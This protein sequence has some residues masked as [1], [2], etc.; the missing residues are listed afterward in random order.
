M[1]RIV[2][3]WRTVIFI[4][5][6]VGIYTDIGHG[7]EDAVSAAYEW[8]IGV[9]SDPVFTING[10]AVN[11]P[12]EPCRSGERTQQSGS[13]ILNDLNGLNALFTPE[14]VSG[15]SEPGEAVRTSVQESYGKLPLYFIQNDGQVDARVQYYEKGSGQ[16][17][18]FTKKGI[19]LSLTRSKKTESA[20]PRSAIPSPQPQEHI[21][22]FPLGANKDP[23]IIAEDMQECKINYFVGSPEKWRTNI[24]TFGAVEYKNIYDGV[25]M[26]FY[27]NNRQMEY[28]V[29]VK[30]GVSPSRVQLCYEGIEDLRI[31][32][33]GDM[34]IILKEGSIIHKKPYIYQII[35]GEKRE[36]EGSF[37]IL[38][39]VCG[40]DESS[41]ATAEW[42]GRTQPGHQVEVIHR[43]DAKGAEP[44]PNL[45]TPKAPP[46]N[47]LQR[48]TDPRPVL[49]QCLALP[50]TLQRVADIYFP[51]VGE[52]GVEG[53]DTCATIAKVLKGINNGDQVTNLIP[54]EPSKSVH[55]ERRH[56]KFV[57]GFT[58]A[59]YEKSSSLVIDP[60]LEYSTYLGGDDTD[61]GY[62]IAVD[63]SGYAYV[64]GF[65]TSANF[66]VVGTSTAKKANEDV[67]VTKL[68]TETPLALIYSTYIGGNGADYGI[69]IAVDGSASAY[70]TGYTSSS[71]FPRAGTSTAKKTNYDAFVTKLGASG[72]SLEYSTYIGGSGS[73]YGQGIAVDSSGAAYVVG[74]TTSTNFPRVGTTTGHA[75]G[76]DDVF[77]TKLGTETPLALIYSTYIGGTGSELGRGI[78]L[79]DSGSAY[80]SGY[81][82]SA[83]FPVVGT[84]TGHAG[85]TYDAFVTK[86][87][88]ETPLA[89]IYSTY[90]GGDGD[91]LAIGIAVDGSGSAYISGHT[92][93]ANFPVVGTTT[94]HAGGI[95]DAFVTKLGTETPLALVYSTCIGGSGNDYCG[96]EID[97]DGSG[98]AYIIG[99]TTSTNFPVVG[100]TTSHAEGTEDAFVIKL[101]TGVPISI[102]YSTYI[103]GSGSDVALGI[104]VDGTD[105][106]YI[107]GY[108]G[109]SNFPI[110]GTSTA[111]KSGDDA[112][113]TKLLFTPLVITGSATSVTTSSVTLS[114]TVSTIGLPTTALF[115]YGVSSGVYTGTSTTQSVTGEN[116]AVSISISDLSAA[117]TYYYR[118][119]ANSSAGTSTGSEQSFTTSSSGGGGGGGGEPKA[120]TLSINSTN[121]LDNAVN[122]PVDAA[123]SA[124]FSMLINGST[125]N[126]DSFYVT[127]PD[128]NKIDGF[129]STD[130]YDVIFTP[131]DALS[132]DTTYT[133]FA[134][135]QI[136]AA[137]WAGT[138]IESNHS[139]SFTT[140]S[141]P[142]VPTPTPAAAAASPT[143]TVLLTPTPT[144]TPQP[145]PTPTVSQDVMTLSKDVA[146]LS[147]DT[148]IVTVADGDRNTDARA[149]DILTTA[150]KVSGDNYYIGSDL[151]LDLNED[152]ADSGTFIATIKTGTTTSGEASATARSNIG[153]VKTVQDG[154]I[155]VAYNP[156]S[157]VSVTKK[158]SF[159]NF[160]ATLA[161]S[162]SAYL[163]GEY[164]EITLNNAESNADHKEAETLLE[165]FMCRPL[166]LILQG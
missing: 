165:K 81:T 4:A 163:L 97:V 14:D 2:R 24:P 150:I 159:S 21:R 136:Q 106:A 161:F 3:L 141:S 166:G 82:T 115:S 102:L 29:I 155:T 67:F 95:Y 34:E 109:S 35:D 145:S 84:T 32:E 76:T 5:L 98:S 83:N 92:T 108:T 37:R 56:H 153:T 1:C 31:R 25:D 16:G 52:K 44:V 74:Y 88:T 53:T 70:I 122:V 138:T 57:Y 147:G 62:G 96:L 6:A 117:T 125:V 99:Y 73:D 100:T 157:A 128:G 61:R 27:G 80:V 28:D 40:L 58:V 89:L 10:R 42:T 49:A 137:N 121:P 151:L 60:I 71:N 144:I 162:R 17:M 105:S 51:L 113:V 66:P 30:P 9:H 78:A 36:I 91:D 22:L 118:S 143:L 104:A 87:G 63:S 55:P 46:P 103:G 8:D 114:A 140:E 94:G 126:T 33:D 43:K 130:S 156:P 86:L 90:I 154:A 13:N 112:F 129:A 64:T 12:A 54:P 38:N 77:V 75:G 39:R 47:P 59:S 148:V 101:G 15:T 111:K 110:V 131:T 79:D 69:G 93:S 116:T 41:P 135:T 68:G 50:G 23:G 127:N 26:R 7:M 107:A 133:A 142:I 85:G 11:V 139:W 72:D 152:G 65:T 120:A 48:G 45:T 20:N 134:T 149:E 18:F 124:T 158:L 164:A 119:A 123:I 146:Y 19:Y 132:Y 160:D